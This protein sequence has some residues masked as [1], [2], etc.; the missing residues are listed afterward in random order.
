M[1][2][3]LWASV[4]PLSIVI[5]IGLWSQ[6]EE[7]RHVCDD[8]NQ[9]VGLVRADPSSALHSHRIR[10][11]GDYNALLQRARL[12]TCSSIPVH[13]WTDESSL[14]GDQAKTLTSALVQR[15]S[16]F[17]DNCRLTGRLGCNVPYHQASCQKQLPCASH[18]SS[19]NISELRTIKRC[20][21]VIRR[22]HSP[23]HHAFAALPA[24]TAV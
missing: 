10:T 7:M 20:E 5:T 3:H 9:V 2:H 1:H 21:I 15:I 22:S 12:P 6:Q 8:D 11:N 17:I 13:E 23:R 19:D 18:T 14:F 24:A 4:T 16:R